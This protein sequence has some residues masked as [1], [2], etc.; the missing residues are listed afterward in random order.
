MAHTRQ[1]AHVLTKPGNKS[2]VQVYPIQGL[3]ALDTAETTSDNM[4]L[5]DIIDV[6]SL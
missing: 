6:Q 4:N 1:S 3:L 2:G 5:H